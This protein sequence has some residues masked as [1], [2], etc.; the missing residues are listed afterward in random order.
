MLHDI[1]IERQFDVRIGIARVQILFVALAAEHTVHDIDDQTLRDVEHH[2]Q[3]F[4][5][6]RQLEIKQLHNVIVAHRIVE[7]VITLLLD[8]DDL[9]FAVCAE[10]AAEPRAGHPAVGIV[11]TF[12]QLQLI[13][14]KLFRAVEVVFFILFFRFLICLR[15]LRAVISGAHGRKQHINLTL[16]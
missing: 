15:L 8:G 2:R 16:R 3:I 7:L 6:I 5:V 10:H 4:A 13:V 1:L 14:G 11:D 9:H 12:Q